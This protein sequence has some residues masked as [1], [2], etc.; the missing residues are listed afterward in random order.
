VRPAALLLPDAPQLER[1]CAA[2]G[3]E[4]VRVGTVAEGHALLARERFAIVDGRLARPRPLEDEVRRRIQAF[5]ERL[6]GERAAG[7]YTAVM[8]EVERPLI[9]GALAQAKGVRATAA[10]ALGIDR[11]TLVRR[12]RALGLDVT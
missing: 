2:A 6:G 3:L 1:A 8:R 9:E 12:M 7:L 5:F 4:I 11:G 10:A